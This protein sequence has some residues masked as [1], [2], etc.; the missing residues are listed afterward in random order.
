MFLKLESSTAKL[1]KT[2]EKI[3]QHE[4]KHHLSTT[5]QFL[6]FAGQNVNSE[7]EIFKEK[8]KFLQISQ[9]LEVHFP[10]TI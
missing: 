3:G 1:D 10:V 7:T 8:W 2:Q 9:A 4:S 6:P 5:F